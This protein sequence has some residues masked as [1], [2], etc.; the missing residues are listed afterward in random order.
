MKSQE[1]PQRPQTCPLQSHGAGIFVRCPL[2]SSTT[3]ISPFR[4]YLPTKFAKRKNPRR[5]VCRTQ[6]PRLH[7]NQKLSCP[8]RPPPLNKSR[9]F[10]SICSAIQ[11]NQ[12]KWS[13]HG[14]LQMQAYMYAKHCAQVVLCF[15]LS[16][17]SFAVFSSTNQQ[18]LYVQSNYK[19]RPKF[20]V[21]PSPSQTFPFDADVD[22]QS[23]PSHIFHTMLYSTPPRISF[24]PMQAMPVTLLLP[25]QP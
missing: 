16:I 18:S 4:M 7:A 5:P 15:T 17:C 23:S 24:S 25:Y 20:Y 14:P 8:G 12:R 9:L 21:N 3:V 2:S 1:P 11:V 13:S 19:S 22:R 6:P 10:V